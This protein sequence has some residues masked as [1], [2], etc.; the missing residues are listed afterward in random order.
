ML[1]ISLQKYLARNYFLSNK[2]K[3]KENTNMHTNLYTNKAIFYT[4][5]LFKQFYFILDKHHISTSYNKK[6]F[7]AINE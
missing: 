4:T 5:K 1:F 7:T 3:K 2:M 6:H